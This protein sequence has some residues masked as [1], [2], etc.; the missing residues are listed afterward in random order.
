M[1]D[2]YK[3]NKTMVISAHQLVLETN[4]KILSSL[5]HLFSIILICGRNVSLLSTR[6]P[7]NLVLFLE[8]FH[9]QI[10]LF[11][12]GSGWSPH[13]LQKSIPTVF[14]LDKLNP[15]YIAHFSILCRHSYNCLSIMFIF[16]SR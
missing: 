14:E 16:V 2:L 1:N 10:I 4:F 15:F 5:W 9:R 3:F 11:K 7:T 12:S 13:L 8:L 6:I